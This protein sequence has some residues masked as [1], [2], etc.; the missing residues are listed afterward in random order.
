MG[1]YNAI[2]LYSLLNAL[3]YYGGVSGIGRSSTYTKE[4]LAEAI[5]KYKAQ[6]GEPETMLNSGTEHWDLKQMA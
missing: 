5:K 3:P 2:E 4:Q 6:F 1:N